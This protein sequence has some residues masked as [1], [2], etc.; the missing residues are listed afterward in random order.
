MSHSEPSVLGVTVA[1]IS[2]DTE[3]SVPRV[4]AG[5]LPKERV[6]GKEVEARAVMAGSYTIVN[7]Q[8]R[9]G[10]RFGAPF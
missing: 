9:G 2:V 8:R 6:K 5:S 7:I 10:Q 1:A 3:D 4:C